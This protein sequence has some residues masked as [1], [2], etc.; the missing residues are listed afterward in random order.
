MIDNPSQPLTPKQRPGT[1]YFK[2]E[3]RFK[4][5]FEGF[6]TTTFNGNEDPTLYLK[7]PWNFDVAKM[8][9]FGSLTGGVKAVSGENYT[10]T[11]TD[12][13]TIIAVTTGA[14]DR[15]VTLPTLADNQGRILTFVKVDD[16]AGELVIDGEGAET[17]EGFASLYIGRRYGFLTVYADSASWLRIGGAIQPVSGEPS[18]GTWHKYD[19][20]STG[21]IVNKASGWTADS[22]SG[23]LE[24]DFGIAGVLR[25]GMKA[26]R[27]PIKQATTLSRVFYRK[28][29]DTNI[30]NTP[31]ASSEFS[32]R[33]LFST[34]S[35]KVAVIWLSADYKAQ[36]AVTNVNTDLAVYYPIEY[37]L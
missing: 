8:L 30:S 19:N 6:E 26:V 14:S 12:G 24:V 20:P 16:G 22:F 32:H 29:G 2:E 15:T 3:S 28:S 11:D 31:N 37:M 17:I 27:V 10:I 7:S 25:A 35:E 9:T 1:G 33:I 23:G 13:F 34:E 36:F 21:F 5:P 18:G 4:F